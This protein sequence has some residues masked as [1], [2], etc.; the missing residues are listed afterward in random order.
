MPL[1]VSNCAKSFILSTLPKSKQM[2]RQAP[3]VVKTRLRGVVFD[4]DGTLTVPVIDFPAMYR[5]VLGDEEYLRLKAENPSGIDI[6][7]HI[8]GWP[9]HKQRKAFDAIAEV[10]RQGLER[11][12]IMP[13]C[14]ELC[15]MLDSKKIRR[16][17]I[18]RNT[19]SA[20]DLFH[21]R[22]GITFSPALSRE[23]RP[24]KP[25]PGPLLHICSLWEVQPNEVIMIG[26]SLKDDVPC[27][28][29]AGAFTCLL[30]QTGVYDSPEYADVEF[31][32][33][34]KVTSLDEVHSVL[35]ENFDL[36][37]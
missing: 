20:V 10:E 11:L 34:F 22:F 29:Q 35:K 5:A 26:D 19:K 23:F 21:E 16:G 25:D 32:P 7:G 37:P 28:R 12:Q 4:M 24:Y 2:S 36:S 14:A 8:D 33:D 9:P 1:L 18:T 15:A 31:K 27:G 17:L 3:G 6:L 13:G 30:D